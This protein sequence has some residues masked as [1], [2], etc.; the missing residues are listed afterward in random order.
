M[1]TQQ[2]SR[3]DAVRGLSL[4][5]AGLGAAGLATAALGTAALAAQPAS[6][7]QGVAP[8]APLAA[9]EQPAGLCVLQPQ[10]VEG[11]YYF[12][13][14]QV[15][16]DIAEGVPGAPVK[17]VLQIVDAQGCAPLSSL[18]VDIWHADARGIYSGYSGQGDRRDVSTKGATYLRGTQITGSDGRVTFRTIYPG[19]YPGRTP[20]IHLKV[21]LDRTT[22]VT[23]QCYFPDDVSAKIYRERAPYSARPVADTSNA[24]DGIFND[25]LRDGGGTVF[26]MESEGDLVVASLLIG[27]DRTGS[28][29]RKA[30]GWSDYMRHLIGR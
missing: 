26:A 14:N 29:A 20:H 11:P 30:G 13:P 5:T 25:S 2:V 3:R 18:R 24:R 28:A 6:A 17:L 22:L 23:G 15:R 12:D 16:R 10:A 27:V 19:W 21:F 4:G 1:M 9:A 8:A 7:D